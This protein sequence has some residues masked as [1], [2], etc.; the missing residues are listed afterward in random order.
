MR[1][2]QRLARLEARKTPVIERPT[3]DASKL[4]GGLLRRLIENRC[5]LS[6]LS[7]ADLAELEAARLDG[8]SE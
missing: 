8:T 4:S 1:L 7:S 3:I 2:K 5:D 6:M